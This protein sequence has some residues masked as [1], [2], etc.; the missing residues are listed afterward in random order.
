MSIYCPCDI[1]AH[2]ENLKSNKNIAPQAY[3][4]NTSGNAI[5][6]TLIENSDGSLRQDIEK[7]VSGE[8]IEHN[9]AEDLTYDIIYQ[10]ENNIWSMLYL[11]GYLTK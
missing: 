9:V 1:L 8:S 2:I 6:R 11:T 5:M 7:L 4:N 3:W 10:N